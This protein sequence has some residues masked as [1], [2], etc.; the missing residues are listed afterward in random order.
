MLGTWIIEH[1]QAIIENVGIVG[2]L[3]FAGAGLLLDARARRAETLIEIT[4]QQRE[5][6]MYLEEHPKLSNV[7]SLNR[8]MKAHPLKDEEVHF[9][10]FLF[11]HLR[12]TYYARAAGIYVQPEGLKEDIQEFFS[13]P[14]V[15]FAWNKLKMRHDRKFV[16]FV[17]RN[18]AEK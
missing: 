8:D 10:N 1:W 5:L 16:A 2:G 3:F 17:D 6:L 14:S 15:R 18:A 12:A 13:Y 9:V 4:K 11:N 7:L